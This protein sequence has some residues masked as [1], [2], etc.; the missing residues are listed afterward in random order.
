M[1]EDAYEIGQI[2][3]QFLHVWPLAGLWVSQKFVTSLASCSFGHLERS[4]PCT[5]DREAKSCNSCA[6]MLSTQAAPWY[7]ENA[8]GLIRTIAAVFFPVGLI[9]IVLTGADLIS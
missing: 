9:M 7:Q 1:Q 8:P 4:R 2:V 5:R 3:L 6:V